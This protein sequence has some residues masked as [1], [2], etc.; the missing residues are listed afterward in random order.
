M[1]ILPQNWI[2]RENMKRKFCEEKGDP[3]APL[4]KKPKVT[5]S[6]HQF[7]KEYGKTDGK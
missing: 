5:S 3:D 4:P 2:R 6:W 1:N 7:M